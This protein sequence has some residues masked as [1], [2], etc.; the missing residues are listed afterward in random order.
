MHARTAL[1]NAEAKLDAAR[2]NAGAAA[3][4]AIAPSVVQ[5][6]AQQDQISAQIQAQQG[7]LGPNHPEALGLQRQYRRRAARGGGG[8]RPRRRRHRSRAARRARTRRHAGAGPAEWGSS[9]G[10]QR[11]RAGPAERDAA[12]RRCVA[13][14]ASGGAGQHPADRAAGRDRIVG[15]A[16]DFAR[17]AAGHAQLPAHRAADGRGDRV[18]RAGRPAAGLSAGAG[19][20]HAALRR[21]GAR[22]VRPAL[23]RAAA[24]DVA[25]PARASERGRI[26]RAQAAL[27]VRRASAGAA[28]RA[29]DGRGAPARRSR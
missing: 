22:G 25:P 2:G 7:R 26:R 5:L 17:A 1:G 20:H 9:G 18:R 3:Q 14:A 4:A 19:R 15:G 24:G 12:R 13:P 8:N 28:G 6:R 16:R 29:V 11:Q 21:S 23:L 27:A 10:P